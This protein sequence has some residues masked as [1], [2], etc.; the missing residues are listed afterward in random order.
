MRKICPDCQQPMIL[1]RCPDDAP[2]YVLSCNCGYREA[3]APDIEAQVE[4]RPRM[5]GL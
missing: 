4:G 2:G 5:P 3:A 1:E